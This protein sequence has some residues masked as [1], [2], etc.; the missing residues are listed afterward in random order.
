[1]RALSIFIF[2][3]IILSAYTTVSAAHDSL[4][5]N[6]I[7]IVVASRDA[8]QDIVVPSNTTPGALDDE[9]SEVDM[10]PLEPV[11]RSPT[12]PMA[13]PQRD[14]IPLVFESLAADTASVAETQVVDLSQFF[15]KTAY[16]KNQVL[17]IISEEARHAFLSRVSNRAGIAF[18]WMGGVVM[19][20]TFI[21]N[22][23]SAANY[24]EPHF[25]NVL[26]SCLIA[27]SALC[28]WV[29]RGLK[30]TSVKYAA[31]SAQKQKALGVPTPLING[32][33]DINIEPL[34][35]ANTNEA[36]SSRQAAS[37][38]NLQSR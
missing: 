6:E 37:Q 4:G 16:I 36:F 34:K 10:I 31:S 1:M 25:G 24:I 13:Q 29:G 12:L 5:L 35:P 33:V 20:T 9:L 23:L 7:N 26:S 32:P 28:L 11:G 38:R 30:Q 19:G 27:G 8:H 21:T 3:F 17:K 15:D 18:Q 2:Q 22:I 14:A